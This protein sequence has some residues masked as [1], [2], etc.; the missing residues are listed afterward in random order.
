M[1][2][3][4]VLSFIFYR[5]GSCGP[6]CAEARSAK[7]ITSRTLM[8]FISAIG[9][10]PHYIFMALAQSRKFPGTS[11]DWCRFNRDAEIN[12]NLIRFGKTF[13]L[14]LISEYE[15][16][17]SDQIATEKKNSYFAFT[18]RLG[19]RKPHHCCCFCCDLCSQLYPIPQNW[20][21]FL[22]PKKKTSIKRVS[23]RHKRNPIVSS[24]ILLIYVSSVPCSGSLFSLLL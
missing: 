10:N 18:L 16:D 19:R 15:S 7:I 9:S 12:G 3:L 6:L 14:H 17:K 22:P 5:L 1:K 23:N 24:W 2:A 21:L 13:A 20:L 4:K 8:C 11:L